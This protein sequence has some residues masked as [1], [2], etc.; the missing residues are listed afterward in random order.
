MAAVALPSN[1]S[2]K[3]K[4]WLRP[5]HLAEEA[6]TIHNIIPKQEVLRFPNKSEQ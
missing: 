2:D 4:H 5:G 3:N 1:I 6:I